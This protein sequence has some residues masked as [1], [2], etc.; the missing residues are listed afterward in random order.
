MNGITT[1][2]HLDIDSDTALYRFNYNKIMLWHGTPEVTIILSI[3]TFISK[4]SES[5]RAL[6]SSPSVIAKS[7]TE[8]ALNFSKYDE[9]TGIK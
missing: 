4:H 3:L 2:D 9:L 8:F 1:N 5:A 7:P 6:F